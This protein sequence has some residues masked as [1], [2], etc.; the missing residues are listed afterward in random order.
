MLYDITTWSNRRT[1]YII[2]EIAS[3]PSDISKE[4]KSMVEPPSCPLSIISSLFNSD[5]IIKSEESLL[6]LPNKFHHLLI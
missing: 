1:T 2:V 3:P 5:L 4:E 6:N